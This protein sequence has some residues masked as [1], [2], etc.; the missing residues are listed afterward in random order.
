VI[1]EAALNGGTPK[2]RNANVPRTPAEIAADGLRCVAA[3]AA[4]VH[5]HNDEPVIGGP[6]GAHDPAPY[7]TAWRA[8]LAERPDAILYPTM[9]GGGPHTTFD[10]RYSHIVALA[11]EGINFMGLVDPGSVNVGALGPDG[12]PLAIET[13]YINSLADARRM[14]EVCDRYR[15]APSVSVFEPGFLRVVLAYHA[16]GRLPS[17]A[18]V[19]LYF[20]G[21]ASP[22]GMPPTSASLEAYLAMLEPTG[23]PWS[24]AVLGG[25]VIECGLAGLAL[26]RGGHLRVGLEDYAGPRQPT[27][28]ELVRRAVAL[29]GARG[30]PVATC[31][32]ARSILSGQE[33]PA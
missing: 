16:A 24:V 4:I 18:L 22:F 19:K 3:G 2:H 33:I 23:L 1:I 17:G 20:G 7:V 28:E 29:C 21:D 26:K 27:N 30:R 6:T 11:E 9:A 12:L 8:I 14:F 5:N 31:A 13:P 32:E 10:E 25:D 15:L